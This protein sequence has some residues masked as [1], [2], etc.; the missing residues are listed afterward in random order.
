MYL[1]KTTHK[2]SQCSD[3][4]RLRWLDRFLNGRMLE[5]INRKLLDSIM[6]ARMVENVKNSSVNRVNEV[7]RSV[8]RTRIRPKLKRRLQLQYREV[9]PL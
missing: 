6:A 3:K 4:T 7:I 2:A 9:L 8:L 5:E 1:A